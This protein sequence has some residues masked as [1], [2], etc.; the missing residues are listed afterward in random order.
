MGI[1]EGL[2]RGAKTLVQG[3]GPQGFKAGGKQIRCTHCGHERFIA[4]SALL[5]TFGMTAMNLAWANKKAT[6]L[7]CDA[8]G[9][10]HWFG[11]PP[12]AT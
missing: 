11:E 10:V 5:N 1:W 9:L 2:K 7:M 3:A 4:G 8:C 6:T 12:V